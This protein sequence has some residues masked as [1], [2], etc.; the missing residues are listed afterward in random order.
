MNRG[1]NLLIKTNR[2]YY[3]VQLGD[4][5]RAQRRASRCRNDAKWN[6]RCPQK[7]CKYSSISWKRSSSGWSGRGYSS[8]RWYG[9][10]VRVHSTNAHI[11]ISWLHGSLEV[12]VHTRSFSTGGREWHDISPLVFENLSLY[13]YAPILSFLWKAMVYLNFFQL[14]QTLI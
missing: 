11:H 14:P 9:I 3:L 10:S 13:K 8:R 6:F 4:E 2:E 5:L 7:S 1:P 12:V